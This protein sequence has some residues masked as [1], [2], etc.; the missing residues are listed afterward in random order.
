MPLPTPAEAQAPSVYADHIAELHPHE[1]AIRLW[2]ERARGDFNHLG[3]Q[4]CADIP[5]KQWDVIMGDDASGRLP[6]LFAG[7][8]VKLWRNDQDMPPPK[9]VFIGGGRVPTEAFAHDDIKAAA[10]GTEP[11]HPFL[12][13]IAKMVHQK[14][15]EVSHAVEHLV[16]ADTVRVLIVTD[17][18]ENGHTLKRLTSAL[19]ERGIGYDIAAF[20]IAAS[21]EDTTVALQTPSKLETANVSAANVSL[22]VANESPM[23]HGTFK[24]PED[25][26]YRDEIH[27]T[28][29]VR[30]PADG[31]V[32]TIP[33]PNANQTLMAVARQT[34]SDL[35]V[36]S[37][38]HYL[39][40]S[41]S[42]NAYR[43]PHPAVHPDSPTAYI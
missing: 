41:D 32:A 37:Y 12:Q 16:P 42:P 38:V 30:R 21:K 19:Q 40:L 36:E 28:Y 11:T 43:L 6:A 22:Y 31:S 27:S 17:Y 1:I 26:P 7:E 18:I 35:A 5:V 13:A 14:Q 8:L 34:I 9:R 25:T 4:L 10:E 3:E 33:N 20:N 23:P 2:L 15:L 24:I 39:V 29:G